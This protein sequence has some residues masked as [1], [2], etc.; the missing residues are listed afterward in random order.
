MT[1]P[2]LRID[3]YY[4][5]QSALN[6]ALIKTNSQNAILQSCLNCNRFNEKTEICKLA[7]QR[8]PA[9]VIAYGCPKWDDKDQIPF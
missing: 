4:D 2:K 8:P 5:I 6:E 1:T 7:N 3:A 9:R